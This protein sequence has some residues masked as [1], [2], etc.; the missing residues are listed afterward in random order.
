MHLSLKGSMDR[1]PLTDRLGDRLLAEYGGAAAA[2]SLRALN[3]NGDS[4]VR[5]RRAS[6]NDEKDFTAEQ[7]ELGEMVNWVNSQ[8]VPPL[9]IGVETSEGRI[10]VPEGGTS[11][12]TPAAAYSLRNLSTT[13]TG[14][15]VDVR[16]SS[17]DAE[18]S[19][20]AAEV[21]DGTLEAW[22]SE[23]TTQYM[24]FDGVGEDI[25][26]P[27]LLPA[28]DDFTLTIKFILDEVPASTMG[29]YGS[30]SSGSSGRHVF[31]INTSG[32]A[33]A[34]ISGVAA[35]TTANS[36]NV[37]AINTF[38]LSRS[39]TN[40]SL[41]LNGGTADTATGSIALDTAGSNIGDPYSGI[42]FNGIIT[43]LSVRTITWDGSAA[44]ATANGWTVNGSPTSTLLNDGFVSQWYD[45]SGNDNHATQGTDASQPKIVDG[46][47]LVSGGLDFDGVDD[48]LRNSNN[49]GTTSNF[50]ISCIATLPDSITN[51]TI[52]SNGTGVLSSGASWFLKRRSGL[53]NALAFQDSSARALGSSAISETQGIFTAESNGTNLKIYANGSEQDSVS[54]YTVTLNGTTIG[55]RLD[56][57][58]LL[59]GQINEVIIYD[60]DQSGNR[61]AIEANIGETY[62]ITG[63]PA[64][65]NTVD[66]FV[67]TWYDQSGNGNDA[68]QSVAASQPK[69]VDGGSLVSGGLDFDGVDDY[70]LSSHI[71]SSDDVLSLYAVGAFDDLTQRMRMMGDFFYVNVSDNGGFII[72]N[73]AFNQSG[74]I[75]GYGDDTL[76]PHNAAS[77]VTEGSESL[78][79]LQLASGSSSFYVNGSNVN[80]ISAT[81]NAEDGGSVL[82]IGGGTTGG[83]PLIGQITEIIIYNADKTSDM[84]NI[85]GNINDHYN[86]Y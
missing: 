75:A 10:P 3:G 6:D 46:G 24:Q 67:E 28:T 20:T 60:S 62:G 64:Y 65:D 36:I 25:S 18:D 57:V 52:L 26:T 41:S 9:D 7:I 5:V 77:F 59:T 72:E 37:G 17:D 63:I 74:R 1:Q 29:L 50:F 34:F 32:Q 53:D 85:R 11:I 51:Q 80:T 82:S 4:V 66:G 47:S 42:N 30:L 84:A 35:L 8:T 49:L 40:W 81:M 45:Q 73:N 31:Q 19:F 44:D 78:F 70:L 71:L 39:G 33:F 43:S 22:V 12:G 56:E 54:A 15:V 38:V 16:R 76:I 23:D 58:S 14:N 79:E 68:T 27:A 48:L 61:T 21:A 83:F 86:I 13:Y 69:I 2:Y 55:A